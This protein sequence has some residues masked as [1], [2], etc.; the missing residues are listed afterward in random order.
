MSNASSSSTS[1]PS[2]SMSNS[3]VRAAFVASVRCRRPPVSRHSTKLSIVPN[4]ISPS[5]ARRRKPAMLSSSQRD[6]RRGEIRIDDEPGALGDQLGKTGGPPA[7]AQRCRATILPDDRVGERPARGT[8]P[9][10][11][12]LALIGDADCRDRSGSGGDRGAAAGDDALPDF[13]RIVLDPARP[14]VMLLE[15]D[16]RGVPH[17]AG[18]VEQHRA[19]AGRPL[20]DRQNT[21]RTGHGPDGSGSWRR[22][23]GSSTT[24]SRRPRPLP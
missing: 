22:G 18:A 15:P 21:R 1:Q 8:L 2:L 23:G 5:R 3:I 14:R 6:L 17:P 19:G 20:V 12:R 13:L 24:G 7:L 10:H 16:L 11:R 4:A 9:Q